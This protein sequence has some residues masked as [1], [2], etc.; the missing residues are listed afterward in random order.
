MTVAVE[1]VVKA[2]WSDCAYAT[3]LPARAHRMQRPRVIVVNRLTLP[4]AR[5]LAGED[6]ESVLWTAKPTRPDLSQ[7]TDPRCLS[8]DQPEDRSQIALN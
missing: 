4:P 1:A 2:A 7:E 5:K 6:R 8:G 3:R